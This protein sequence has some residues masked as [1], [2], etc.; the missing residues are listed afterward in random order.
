M[1]RNIIIKILKSILTTAIIFIINFLGFI[2]A[3][4]ATSINSFNLYS[5]G[6][7][8]NLL[9]YKG[10]PVKVSYIEYISNGTNYPA[11]CLDKTKPGAEQGGYAVSVQEA[12]KDV[13]L[14]KIIINGYPY[15]T[16]E[17]LGVYNKEEAFTA[18]KQA[19]YCYIHGNN[20]DDY[21]GIGE[22]GTRTLNALKQIIKNA[23]SSTENKISSTIT[24][25]RESQK[26]EQDN[27]DKNYVS[28][29]YNISA[30][31]VI[32][33][34]KIKITKENGQDI[35]GIKLTDEN[36]IEKNEFNRNEKFKILIPIKNMTESGEIKIEVNAEIKTKPVLF[37]KSPNS[38]YQDYALTT[39]SF[40]EGTG[41]IKD[42]Y[43]KNEM[44]STMGGIKYMMPYSIYITII[45]LVVLV[46]W[47][48]IGIPIGIGSLPGV[49]YGA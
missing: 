20:P 31:A 35:G 26:W 32:D 45:W 43:N 49:I 27:I 36:N 17:E 18:T 2:N 30:G 7:C 38:N 40:E 47:Y 23:Q 46:A 13:E 29:I 28:K 6:E 22:A 34:Y 5:I 9:T 24:I 19:V 25:N 15:K 16:L 33:R 39:A 41:N 11:Y 42:K 8:G 14:W 3:V 48:M 12:I 1:K 44:I 21:K 4:N 10:I 37:G